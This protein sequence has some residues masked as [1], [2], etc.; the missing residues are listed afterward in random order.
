MFS[1]SVQLHRPLCGWKRSWRIES[2]CSTKVS[3]RTKTVLFLLSVLR[4]TFSDKRLLSAVCE[5]WPLSKFSTPTCP[6]VFSCGLQCLILKTLNCVVP[7]PLVTCLLKSLEYPRF[8]QNNVMAGEVGIK[9]VTLNVCSVCSSPWSLLDGNHAASMTSGMVSPLW[10]ADILKQL[11][12]KDCSVLCLR[13]TAIIY[14]PGIEQKLLEGFCG[15]GSLCLDLSLSLCTWVWVWSTI[16]VEDV[17]YLSSNGF[18][19]VSAGI[20]IAL[21]SIKSCTYVFGSKRFGASTH[22]LLERWF[23]TF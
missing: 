11:Y 10:E 13:T 2:Q 21:K 8:A 12:G 14:D 4:E 6:Q 18:L 23:I 22:T 15:H 16:S 20:S 17:K 5:H 9:S 3:H 1:S 7:A 19:I